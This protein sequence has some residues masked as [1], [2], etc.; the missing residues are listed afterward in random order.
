MGTAPRKGCPRDPALPHP[1]GSA[2][3][4]GVTGPADGGKLADMPDD[5]RR[6]RDDDQTTQRPAEGEPQTPA[7]PIARLLANPRRVRRA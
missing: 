3:D 4:L 6:E 1:F 7:S 2:V 5:D